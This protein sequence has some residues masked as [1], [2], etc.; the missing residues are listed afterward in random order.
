MPGIKDKGDWEARARF[1][2]AV[3]LG[4]SGRGGEAAAARGACARNVHTYGHWA[5]LDPFMA[6]GD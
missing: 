4:A 2:R 6:C 5:W 1:G 3:S